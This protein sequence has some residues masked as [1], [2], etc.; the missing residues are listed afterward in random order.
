MFNLNNGSLQA[1]SLSATSDGVSARNNAKP[2][3]Q[4]RLEKEAEEHRTWQELLREQFKDLNE[5]VAWMHAKAD[6]LREEAQELRERINKNIAMMQ[7]NSTFIGQAEKFLNMDKDEQKA[8]AAAMI[9]SLRKRGYD[10]DDD[11]PITVLVSTYIPTAIEDANDQNEHAELDND[12]FEKDADAKDAQA[13]TIDAQADDIYQKKEAL[14]AQN[15]SPQKFQEEEDK[16]WNGVDPRVSWHYGN[17]YK[18]LDDAG[19]A[20]AE[21]AIDAVANSTDASESMFGNDEPYDKSTSSPTYNS[22]SVG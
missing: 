11:T 2:T 3:S 4:A 6:E 21:K 12:V 7:E 13:D 14:K 10:V 1:M 18:E 22:P 5:L 16:L 19:A 20:N 9:K 15:L 8:N 17:K